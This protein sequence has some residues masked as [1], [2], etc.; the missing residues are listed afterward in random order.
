MEH[1]VRKNKIL[2]LVGEGKGPTTR[3]NK[4]QSIGVLEEGLGGAE[5]QNLF[6]RINFGCCGV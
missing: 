3:S 2:C 6:Q 5:W 4:R 1:N